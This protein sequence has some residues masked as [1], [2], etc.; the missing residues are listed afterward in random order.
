VIPSRIF[1][2]D[3]QPIV[4]EGLLRIFE[5]AGEF[6]I[7]GCS[8]DIDAARRAVTQDAP[9]IFLIGQPLQLRSIVPLIEQVREWNLSSH[10]VAW[11]NEISE[12]DQFRALQMGVRGIIGRTQPVGI[13]LECLHTVAKGGIWFQGGSRVPRSANHTPRNKFTPRELQIIECVC[14]G[15]KNREIAEALSITPG[16][17]KVHLMHIFEKAGVSD[18]FQLAMQGRMLLGIEDKSG[19]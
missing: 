5:R 13:F 2:S 19:V 10:V 7:T 6:R 1:V 17:V 18:R 4:I 9:D 3:N 14:K 15:L 12:G 8:G 16:T 11:V